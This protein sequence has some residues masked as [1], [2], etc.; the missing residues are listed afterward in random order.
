LGARAVFDLVCAHRPE[1]GPAARIALGKPAQVIIEMPLDL[2]LGLHHE[3]QACPITG[4]RGQRTDC[5]GARVPQRIEQ[6]R[7]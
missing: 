7:L 4:Q 2:A 5:E 3:A 6:T 1:N